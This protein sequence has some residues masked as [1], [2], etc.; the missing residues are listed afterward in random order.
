MRIA[1]IG[2]G[3]IGGSIGMAARERGLAEVAGF[4]RTPEHGAEAV[5]LGAVDE[6]FGSIPE[7]VADS[8]IV[9]CCASV[10]AME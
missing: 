9:F 7:A 10:G 8:E 3:L 2:V 1:I 5:D 4:A 6:L